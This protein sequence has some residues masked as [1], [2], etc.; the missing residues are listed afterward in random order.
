M[1]L[2]K[3]KKRE[4][5]LPIIS[6]FPVMNVPFTRRRWTTFTH[7]PGMI[8]ICAPSRCHEGDILEGGFKEKGVVGLRSS[9][10]NV[11]RIGKS[12]VSPSDPSEPLRREQLPSPVL[13]PPEWETVSAARLHTAG[14]PVN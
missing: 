12:V 2:K 13:S 7:R 14:L 10:N 11:L 6:R 8:V 5:G 4:R 1:C 3:K 9:A